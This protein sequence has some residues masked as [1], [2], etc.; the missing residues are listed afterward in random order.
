M[1][2]NF[3]YKKSHCQKTLSTIPPPL[4]TAR[5]SVSETGG[6]PQSSGTATVIFSFSCK[7]PLLAFSAVT[8]WSQRKTHK[9]DPL[10]SWRLEASSRPTLRSL[11]FCTSFSINRIIQTFHTQQITGSRNSNH[12]SQ[13]ITKVSKE[14]KRNDMYYLFTAICLQYNQN[15]TKVH[16]IFLNSATLQIWLKTNIPNILAYSVFVNQLFKI[17]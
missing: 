7:P 16:V 13:K 3:I 4:R 5:W 6:T 8:T 15:L 11:Q 17:I 2:G 1:L 12:I 14:K 9:L 10:G